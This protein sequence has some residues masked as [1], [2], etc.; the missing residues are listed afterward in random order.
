[1]AMK[2]SCPLCGDVIDGADE[3]SLVTAADAHGDEKHGGMHAPREMI[4]A[5]ATEA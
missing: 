4:L 1:M 3:D 2:V 5:N